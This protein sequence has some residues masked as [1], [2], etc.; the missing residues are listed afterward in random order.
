MVL[1][2]PSP[3]QNKFFYDKEHHNRR[4]PM[5]VFPYPTHKRL[6]MLPTA[7]QTLNQLILSQSK[8][9]DEYVMFEKEPYKMM[10]VKELKKGEEMAPIDE[11]VSMIT[12]L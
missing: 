3:E 4:I 5:G 1:P 12:N 7:N 2:P 11:D 6:L 10:V 8:H 9:N